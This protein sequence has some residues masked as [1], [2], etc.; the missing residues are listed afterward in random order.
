MPEREFCALPSNRVMRW[1]VPKHNT[2]HVRATDTTS[3]GWKCTELEFSG[4]HMNL[5]QQKRST[6]LQQSAKRPMGRRTGKQG[7]RGS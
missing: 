1:C 6:T 7:S 2:S 3:M 5:F 4:Y